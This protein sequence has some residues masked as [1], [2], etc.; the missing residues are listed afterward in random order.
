M[1]IRELLDWLD[2]QG[3]IVTDEE[4]LDETLREGDWAAGLDTIVNKET[5]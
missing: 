2:G 5:P 3:L 1:T 4:L